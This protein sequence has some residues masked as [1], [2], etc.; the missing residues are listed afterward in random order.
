MLHPVFTGNADK[1]VYFLPSHIGRVILY[2]LAVEKGIPDILY[3]HVIPHSWS[4]G[5]LS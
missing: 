3:C 1:N 2:D 5:K 4:P